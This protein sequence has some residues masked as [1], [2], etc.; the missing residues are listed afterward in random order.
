MSPVVVAT[1]LMATTDG[2][3]WVADQFGI[4]QAVHI[5]TAQDK[6]TPI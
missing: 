2:K 4:K 5:I 1:V 3:V 6:T